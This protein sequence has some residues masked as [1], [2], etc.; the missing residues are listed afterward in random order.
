MKLKMKGKRRRGR[1]SLRWLDNID[2]HLK[3][4]NKSLTLNEV[5]ET[6]SEMFRESKRLEDIDFLIWIR[7]S[8]EYP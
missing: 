7:S 4:E 8:R 1:P 3:G 2:S 6:K 5:L